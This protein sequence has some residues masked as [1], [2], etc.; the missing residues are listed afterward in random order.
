MHYKG[1]PLLS[2]Q[3]TTGPASK[4]G[5]Q[6]PVQQLTSNPTSNVDFAYTNGG[7]VGPPVS[8][9]PQGM[10]RPQDTQA[11]VGYCLA[12]RAT[13]RALIKRSMTVQAAIKTVTIVA[14]ANSAGGTG[15]HLLDL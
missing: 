7:P 13:R 2:L 10:G 5:R 12:Y 1:A 15:L 4:T 6:T 9:H 14:R 11:L 3:N 8:P